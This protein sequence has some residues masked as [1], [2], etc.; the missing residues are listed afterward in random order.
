MSFKTTIFIGIIFSLCSGGSVA[1]EPEVEFCAT[2]ANQRITLGTYSRIVYFVWNRTSKPIEFATPPIPVPIHYANVAGDR[3]PPTFSLL[4][5]GEFKL[6][7]ARVPSGGGFSAD[8]VGEYN[9][10]VTVQIRGDTEIETL[11]QVVRYELVDEP[12]PDRY[13]V[14]RRQRQSKQLSGEAVS[15]FVLDDSAYREERKRVMAAVMAGRSQDDVENYLEGK[16][17]WYDTSY[18]H[19]GFGEPEDWTHD[20]GPKPEFSLIR[21]L[22][23][24]MDGAYTVSDLEYR[25]IYEVKYQAR[26]KY[27][28]SPYYAVKH[29]IYLF[30][31]EGRN[32]ALEYLRGLNSE[33]WS[34]VEDAIL[35]Y[36]IDRIGSWA[37][38]VAW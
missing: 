35:R 18:G 29:A 6:R 30:R 12:P 38:E 13:I 15:V 27:G 8:I 34:C 16:R 21:S 9:I 37:I 14:K 25:I 3:H 33:G 2:A 19:L 32:P 4:N 28:L 5:P 31:E 26:V 17:Q 36:F 11:E 24:L 22:D 7:V 10:P 20:R 23:S 1:S